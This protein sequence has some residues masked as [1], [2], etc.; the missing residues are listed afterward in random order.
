MLLVRNTHQEDACV[1]EANVFLQSSGGQETLCTLT[2]EAKK[3]SD[4]PDTLA[5]ITEALWNVRDE[6]LTRAIAR[7]FHR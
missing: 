5:R 2:G 7:S 6:G 3:E 4:F 1:V